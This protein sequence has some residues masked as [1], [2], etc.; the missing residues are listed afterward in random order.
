MESDEFL[1]LWEEKLQSPEGQSACLYS[2]G[3]TVANHL[4]QIEEGI[5]ADSLSASM[6]HLTQLWDMMVD[7]G[8]DTALIEE[9]WG[10]LQE[11]CRPAP[12]D[13]VSVWDHLLGE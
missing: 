8:A 7:A 1:A 13:G 9:L 2:F 5:D 10:M 3:T 12:S 6:A 4:V 11:S